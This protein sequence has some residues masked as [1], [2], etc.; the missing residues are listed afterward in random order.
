[1]FYFAWQPKRI[2]RG[3]GDS[4]E[5]VGPSLKSLCWQ[6]SWSTKA[7]VKPRPRLRARLKPTAHSRCALPHP[8]EKPVAHSTV[9]VQRPAQSDALSNGGGLPRR[10]SEI[11]RHSLRVSADIVVTRGVLRF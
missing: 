4:E 9:P 1:M 7:R 2:K 3:A 11:T 6:A 5:G 10:A 8:A